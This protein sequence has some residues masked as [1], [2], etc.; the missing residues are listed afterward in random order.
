[1]RENGFVYLVGAGPGD[2]GLI[3]C[4]G[5]ECIQTADCLVYD[6]L[7]SQ[8]L[9]AH[10]RPDAERV[11]VGKEAG[12]HALPQ[13]EINLL[14]IARAREG[15][16]VCRL[17]G[18]DPYVFGR[19]GEEAAA[20]HAAGIPFAVVPGVTSAIAVPAYAGIPVTHRGVASSFAVITGHEDP[21]KPH[22]SLRW[23]HLSTAADTLVFLMGVENLPQIV[24]KLIAHGRPESTPVA[25]IHQGTTPQQQTVVGTL[26]DIAARV[27]ESGLRP[28]AVTV[29]GEVVCLREPL[30]WFD[31]QPL[32]GR[33]IVVTRARAQASDLAAHL[34]RLGAEVV[35]FPTIRIVPLEWDEEVAGYD[36]LLFT[37]AN[38]VACFF[39]RI[40]SR[41]GD[42]R[43]IGPARLGAIGP[44]TAAAL[45][46]RGLRVDY[47]P[48]R[49]VAEEVADHFPED[50]RGKRIL[51]PTARQARPVLA[52]RLTAR[53]A[54]VRVLPVY[55]TVPDAAAADE[56]AA[57]IRAGTVDLVTFTS[58]STVRHFVDA[59][60][61]A[62]AAQVPAAVIGPLTAETARAAG[63]K[64]AI[65]AGEHTIPG[66]V[67]AVVAHFSA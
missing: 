64:V 3:T 31:S 56:I 29:V 67:D 57:Q 44:A 60:G 65:E 5:L 63:L 1:M 18:G 14:L 2:P 27:Q 51:I 52:E 33:R 10:A 62:L 55:E 34:E 59:L 25:V 43:A 11:Y 49:F 47:V 8:R 6:R 46:A 66:L 32:F 24:A 13:E 30:R 53:G 58:S 26:A 38:G 12:R 21:S 9:L 17:K 15:K 16:L 4:R 40:W 35:E 45:E 50:P 20:L 22:S 23:E 28:P 19:G 37:S 48:P 39:D 41:G 61:A 54:T 36:W 7:A 42:V